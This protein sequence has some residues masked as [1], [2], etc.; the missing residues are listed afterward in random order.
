MSCAVSH[1]SRLRASAE[2]SRPGPPSISDTQPWLN[3]ASCHDIQP[4][5]HMQRH[6]ESSF[7]IG[8][9]SRDTK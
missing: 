8:I 3:V 7:Q 1:H 6:T 2:S 5:G 4:A 9:L